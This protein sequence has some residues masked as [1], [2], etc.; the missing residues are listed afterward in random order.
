VVVRNVPVTPRRMCWRLL[1]QPSANGAGGTTGESRT[2]ARNPGDL[3]LQ[4]S[5]VQAVAR[6]RPSS[7][8]T[9]EQ[10]VLTARLNAEG[11][12]P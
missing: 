6:L 11:E 1:M 12:V 2:V 9:P 4:W 8:A 5:Q 10:E 7:P 3:D